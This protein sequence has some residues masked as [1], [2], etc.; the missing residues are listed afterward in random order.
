MS[1]AVAALLWVAAGITACHAA[2][3]AKEQQFTSA[4]AGYVTHRCVKLEN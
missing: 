4:A 2:A 3:A 1:I